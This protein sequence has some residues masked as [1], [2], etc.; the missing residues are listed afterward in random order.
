MSFVYM[1]MIFL[2]SVLFRNDYQKI[3]IPKQ[4]TGQE[5][6]ILFQILTLSEEANMSASTSSLSST[7]TLALSLVVL[8][9]TIRVLTYTT[10]S[11]V[12]PI[13]RPMISLMKKS[14]IQLELQNEME[15]LEKCRNKGFVND[16]VLKI[17]KK[18][19]SNEANNTY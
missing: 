14:F 18:N 16:K 13:N 8:F 12:F 4:N 19:I 1:R 17:V 6:P 2:T 11:F 5:Y 3:F 7:S 15:E 9:P 10:L